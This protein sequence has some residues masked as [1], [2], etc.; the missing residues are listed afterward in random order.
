[1]PCFSL[2]RSNWTLYLTIPLCTGTI[3]ATG[4][5]LPGYMLSGYTCQS[6][7][8]PGCVLSVRGGVR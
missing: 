7:H 6:W 2:P 8:G 4:Y 1:M 3:S 5:M